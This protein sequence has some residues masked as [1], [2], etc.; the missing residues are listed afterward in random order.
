MVKNIKVIEMDVKVVEMD[1]KMLEMD[2][3]VAESVYSCE[4]FEKEYA[5]LQENGLKDSE[6]RHAYEQ[7]LASPP[8]FREYIYAVTA[9]KF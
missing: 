8:L 7:K 9:A 2:A 3:E 6:L 5:L 1:A 4:K